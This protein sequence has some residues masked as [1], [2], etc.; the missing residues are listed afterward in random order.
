M[1]TGVAVVELRNMW[2]HSCHDL[3]IYLFIL[4]T[5][6]CIDLCSSL[7]IVAISS[8]SN[9]DRTDSRDIECEKAADGV[10]TGGHLSRE[11]IISVNIT[12]SQGPFPGNTGKI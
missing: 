4:K 6:S 12:G 11:V 9:G 10:S 1:I 5:C 2:K 7:Q 8:G 3:F